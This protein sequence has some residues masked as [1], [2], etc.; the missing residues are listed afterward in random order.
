VVLREGDGLLAQQNDG[1]L[2]Q[3]AQEPEI[4]EAEHGQKEGFAG[5]QVLVSGP[6]ALEGVQAG[7][8]GS[9]RGGDPRDPAAGNEADQGDAQQYPAKKVGLVVPASEEEPPREVPRTMAMKVVISRKPL[10]RESSLSGRISG[11]CRTW[12][13]RRRWNGSHEEQHEVKAGQVPP[14]EEKEGESHDRHLEDLHR[15]H[16]APL[17]MTVGEEARPSG[18]QEE[19]KK[20]EEGREGGVT[21][22]LRGEDLQGGEDD[23]QRDEVVV[24][25]PQELG[26][27]V[28]LKSE[29]AEPRDGKRGAHEGFLSG[30]TIR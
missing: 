11:G 27:K 16:H 3:G 8:E 26:A 13:A 29:R 15:D 24:E 30:W 18:E 9:L 14:R 21:A 17:G 25:S 10:A 22:P 1:E 6:Q 4:G 23:D 12:M 20:A 19:R 7:R 5:P 2:D 28:T